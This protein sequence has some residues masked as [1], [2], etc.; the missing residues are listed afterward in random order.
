MTT[1][2]AQLQR[3]FR[4][5]RRRGDVLRRRESVVIDLDVAEKLIVFL[6][7]GRHVERAERDVRVVALHLHA[8]AIQVIV[9][10][11]LEIELHRAAVDGFGF[12]LEGLFDR[13]QIVRSVGGE[14]VAGEEG[15]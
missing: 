7:A 10:G 11:D 8:F 14:C 3:D 4:R 9:V 13:Q 1:L 5:I 15:E 6:L 2:I 12:D